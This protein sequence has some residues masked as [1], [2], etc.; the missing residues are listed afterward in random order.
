[1][2]RGAHEPAG[3]GDGGRISARHVSDRDGHDL[4]QAQDLHYSDV[5]VGLLALA[6]TV[7]LVEYSVCKT[8]ACFD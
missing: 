3:D 6:R 2:E 7:S 1:M 8:H 4:Q 5:Q